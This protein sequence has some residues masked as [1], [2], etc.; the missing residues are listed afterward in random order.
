MPFRVWSWM[1]VVNCFTVLAF[2]VTFNTPTQIVAGKPPTKKNRSPF[3]TR[4]GLEALRPNRADYAVST[5]SLDLWFLLDQC[6]SVDPQLRPTMGEI[7][8][9]PTFGITQKRESSTVPILKLVPFVSRARFRVFEVIQLIYSLVNGQLGWEG[10]CIRGLTSET[11]WRIGLLTH[12][13]ARTPIS[14]HLQ[15]KGHFR[16]GYPNEICLRWQQEAMG[17]SPGDT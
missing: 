9:S 12:S 13:P 8:A 16:S 6:W 4:E 11:H 14:V 10:N 2:P 15:E 17:T 7:L 3:V 5:V 1:Y